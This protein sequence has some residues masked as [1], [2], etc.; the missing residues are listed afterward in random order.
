MAG[1]LA[2]KSG[3]AAW[4]PFRIGSSRLTLHPCTPVPPA[5]TLSSRSCSRANLMVLPS[6]SVHPSPPISTHSANPS[7]H[8][9]ADVQCIAGLHEGECLRLDSSIEDDH[10]A[11]E[12][13]IRSVQVPIPL[14]SSLVVERIAAAAALTRDPPYPRLPPRFLSQRE[15]GA[16]RRPCPLGRSAVWAKDGGRRDRA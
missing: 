1:N 9:L 5:L 2:R 3:Y 10:P 15:R 7:L 16:T 13:A 12:P 4:R 14:L 11:A 6:T 8:S